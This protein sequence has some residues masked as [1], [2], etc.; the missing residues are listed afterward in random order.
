[1]YI[2]GVYVFN[3]YSTLYIYI[4]A[5][6]VILARGSSFS[7]RQTYIVVITFSKP[8][9]KH[10]KSLQMICKRSILRNP[11]P[12]SKSLKEL[13][14]ANDMRKGWQP[15]ASQ[16][17]W[18]TRARIWWGGLTPRPHVSGSVKSTESKAV[19]AVKLLPY[20]SSWFCLKRTSYN[21]NKDSKW[22][23][24][25]RWLISFGIHIYICIYT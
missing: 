18:S 25:T 15:G 2:L 1:M 5:Y 22:T 4:C 16:K 12:T 13:G 17:G 24:I 10:N 8:S 3:M 14:N 6:S 23:P 7:V 9:H 21:P 20:S 19:E 11:R